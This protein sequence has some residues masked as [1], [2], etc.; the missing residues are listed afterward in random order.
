MLGTKILEERRSKYNGEVKV[1][2]SLGFGTYIQ[3]EGLTQSGGIVEDFWKQT[4]K[5][6]KSEKL[7]V[8]NCLVL[9]LG[10]GT[11]AKL[12]R[13]IWPEAK[14]IGVDLDPIMVEL[15]TKYLGLKKTE[16]KIEIG[17]ADEFV[18]VNSKSKKK[19]D[20]VLVDLYC[21]YEFPKK[22]ESERFLKPVSK[23]LT[24][25]GVAVFNHLFFKGK[26]E[27]A[28]EFGEKLKKVFLKVNLFY[29]QANIMFL[30][31]AH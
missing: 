7:K 23:L 30:C 1:V 8:K 18:R 24:D 15:G 28:L 20:L 17:D 11:V 6:V 13:K 25:R 29:P 16:T 14:I 27:E 31:Y 22:F 9:G 3:A 4:L 19:F 10:G 5:K 2:R 12:V 26:K 21:G